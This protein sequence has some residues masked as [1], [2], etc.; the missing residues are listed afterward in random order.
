M[1]RGSG[2]FTGRDHARMSQKVFIGKQPRDG[3]ST[4]RKYYRVLL[5]EDRTDQ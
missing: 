1:E 2:G 4:C 5:R 3:E